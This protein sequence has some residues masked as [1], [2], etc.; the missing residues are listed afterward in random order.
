MSITHD[1]YRRARYIVEPASELLLDIVRP[2]KRGRRTLHP[3][4]LLTGQY[5]A[6]EKYGIATIARTYQV[7]TRDLPRE[8]Q[9]DLGVLSGPAHAPRQLAEHHLYRLSKRINPALDHSSKRASHVSPDHR[10]RRRER[11]DAL[12]AAILMRTLIPRPPGS[13]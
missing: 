2:D 1:D 13:S 3:R 4:I 12:S 5:L 6:I 7:L 10:M 8:L 11:L 9:W